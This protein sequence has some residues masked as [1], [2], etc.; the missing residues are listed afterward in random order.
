VSR[1]VAVD[2]GDKVRSAAGC[3]L[4]V[5]ASSRSTR[6]DDPQLNRLHAAGSPAA[7]QTHAAST[8]H[9]PNQ[10]AAAPHLAAKGSSFRILVNALGHTLTPFCS[11]CSQFFSFFLGSVHVLQIS[12]GDAYPVFPRLSCLQFCALKHWLH[13][14]N[15]T[16]TYTTYIITRDNDEYVE[17]DQIEVYP[18][19]I[20]DVFGV[21]VLG[22]LVRK[23]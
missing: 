9:W 3:S 23:Q 2:A 7:Q 14:L 4:G 20:D 15:I 21:V 18:A 11:V 6:W 12:S 19:R 5:S 22:W 8:F 17:I 10:Y 13:R 16:L 1:W